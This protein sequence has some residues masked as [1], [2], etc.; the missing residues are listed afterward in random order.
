MH[1]GL[2][3]LS[4]RLQRYHQGLFYPNVEV[5]VIDFE[6][7][8]TVWKSNGQITACLLVSYPTFSGQFLLANDESKGAYQPVDGVVYVF[9]KRGVDPV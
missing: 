5:R 2:H 3:V 9:V 8:G 6:F 1:V 4:D 7:A